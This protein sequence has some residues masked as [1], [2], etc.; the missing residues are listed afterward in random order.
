ML[1]HFSEK[2]LH[3]HLY[4]KEK[5]ASGEHHH[6]CMLSAALHCAASSS[7]PFEALVLAF[8]CTCIAR[9]D[10]SKHELTKVSARLEVF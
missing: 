9:V 7:D 8:L 5:T 2:L 1:A 3:L 4:C 10:F 6:F